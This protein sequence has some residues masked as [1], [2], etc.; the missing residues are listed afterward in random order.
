MFV[1][2][3]DVARVFI[4]VSRFGACDFRL[5]GCDCPADLIDI[6]LDA[7]GVLEADHIAHVVESLAR[8][9]VRH[10]LTHR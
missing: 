10:C 4:A 7:L 2:H 9:I 6:V 1:A 5:F 3:V 8:R